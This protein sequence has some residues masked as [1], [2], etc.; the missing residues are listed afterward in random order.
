[1]VNNLKIIIAIILS[2][3]SLGQELECSIVTVVQY[4]CSYGSDLG[5]CED[6]VLGRLVH[7]HDPGY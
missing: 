7:S 3:G 1:M 2:L 6:R 4:G 5:G